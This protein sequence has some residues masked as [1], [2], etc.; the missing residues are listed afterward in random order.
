[1][2]CLTM[3]RSLLWDRCSNQTKLLNVVRLMSIKSDHNMSQNCFSD[4][5]QL[6][7]E[8]C[9]ADNRVLKKL[10]RVKKK[11]LKFGT[12]HEND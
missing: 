8:S 2:I 1:M 12:R 5:M 4:V 3:L 6:V 11:G 10:L 7:L 9:P